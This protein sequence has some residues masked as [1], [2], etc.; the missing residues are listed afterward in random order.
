MD[1]RKV[2]A[3]LE[4]VKLGSINKA[5]LQL[6]YTQ[7]GLSYILN[8]LEDEIGVKLLI[9]NHSGI[10]LT[11]DGEALF[12]LME[13]LI[14]ADTNLNDRL[15]QIKSSSSGLLR[16]GSYSSL[17]IS[18]LPRVTAA[19][20]KRHPNVKFEIHTGVIEMGH[21]LES[22]K[23]DIALCEKHFAGNYSWK[24]ILDDEMWVAVHKSLPLAKKTLIKLDELKPY[25]VIFPNINRKN[26]LNKRLSEIGLDFPNKTE[27]YTED[28][29]ITLAMVQQSH[30]VSFV[31]RLYLPECPPNVCLIPIDPPVRRS[32]GAA[33]NQS[34]SSNK[35]IHALIKLMQQMPIEK[36]F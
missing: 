27:I 7:S 6:G 9:R 28:G 8:S 12:P 4:T 35:L 5:A 34:A 2:S 33:V 18:W 17:L 36:P 30:A 29:S 3:F 23:I 13:N 16:I 31:T 11:P 19:F 25:P 22:G 26:A 21:W 20:R 14:T 32:I 10:A 24:K 1:T 15:S